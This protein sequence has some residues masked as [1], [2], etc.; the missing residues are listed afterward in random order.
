[1]GTTKLNGYTLATKDEL[2]YTIKCLKAF[3]EKHKNEGKIT[4]WFGDVY[5]DYIENNL[6]KLCNML[7]NFEHED[8]E[9]GMVKLWLHRDMFYVIRQSL[10]ENVNKDDFNKYFEW[11]EAIDFSIMHEDAC[12]DQE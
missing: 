2:S 7:G 9:N 6:K 8:L 10:D 1:M 11:V 4:Y 5:M 3:V 12:M